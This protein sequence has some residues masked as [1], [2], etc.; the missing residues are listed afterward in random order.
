M[1]SSTEL[2]EE[3]ATLEDEILHLERYLLSLYRTAFE[4]HRPTLPDTHG[5]YL[6]YKIGSSPKILS[7]QSHQNMKPQV[8]KDGFVHR[9]KM[10][11]TGWA[12]PDNPDFVE[13][14]KSKSSKVNTPPVSNLSNLDLVKRTSLFVEAC[15]SL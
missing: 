7:N 15:N 9:A 1:Q 11:P 3:I 14:L 2:R 5:S 8:S 4:E 6:Q 12:N 13:V 10:S